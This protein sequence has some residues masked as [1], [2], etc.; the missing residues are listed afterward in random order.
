MATFQISEAEWRQQ[1]HARLDA[2]LDL[3][4][5]LEDEAGMPHRAEYPSFA[6]GLGSYAQHS[7]TPAGPKA[8]ALLKDAIAVT[9]DAVGI[10]LRCAALQQPAEGGPGQREALRTW[11][12]TL[13]PLFKL[14]A[15]NLL[16]GNDCLEEYTVWLG[17][18]ALDVGEV[19]EIFR[20]GDRGNRPANLYSLSVARLSALEWKRRLIALGHS[21][22]DANREITTAY[23]EQ[24]DTI[25]KWKASCCATLSEA[26]VAAFLQHAETDEK[27]RQSGYR[28]GLFGKIMAEPFSVRLERAGQKY[29][30]EKKLAADLSPAK[31][32]AARRAEK[33]AA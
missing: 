29:R 24:W 18:R 32:R 7:T 10:P 14:P 21:E 17:L 27:F 12:S 26:Y 2:I 33:Q 5:E 31:R 22:G 23:G 20:P 15:P 6:L 30:Y 16:A 11:L 13:E 9:A 8:R 25:R 4:I 1:L 3:R 19:W 28:G